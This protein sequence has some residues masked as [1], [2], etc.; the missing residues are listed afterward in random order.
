MKIFNKHYLF[1]F[2]LIATVTLAACGGGNSSTEDSSTE[3]TVTTASGV[4]TTFATNEATVDEVFEFFYDLGGDEF[5]GTI[6]WGDNTETRVRGSGSAR[7]IYRGDGEVSI[8]IQIDGG[9]SERVATIIVVSASVV[10]APEVDEVEET[11]PTPPTATLPSSRDFDCSVSSSALIQ[12]P[13]TGE[14]IEVR[15]SVISSGQFVVDLLE[16][17]QL[18][19]TDADLCPAVIVSTNAL[20]ATS[21]L[22]AAVRYSSINGSNI[23]NFAVD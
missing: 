18:F 10:S 11:N 20:L 13:T 2:S 9:D 1:I 7:H 19:S 14:V 6:R 12:S 16:S 4:T 23:Y 17:S 8:A 5:T 3:V 21:P 22:G 15:I